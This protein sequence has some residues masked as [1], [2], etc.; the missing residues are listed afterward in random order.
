M[1]IKQE[2]GY[3]HAILGTES[4]LW[5][6]KKKKNSLIWFLDFFTK[7]AVFQTFS[8]LKVEFFNS[9]DVFIYDANFC[10]HYPFV[11]KKLQWKVAEVW[12]ENQIFVISWDEEV[13]KPV[14]FSISQ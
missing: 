1:V 5:V 7:R 10:V 3:Q 4:H 14:A 12:K 6:E 8:S 11:T 2:A 13:W 9:F